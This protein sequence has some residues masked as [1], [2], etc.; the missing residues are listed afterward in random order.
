MSYV[1]KRI[2]VKNFGVLD[3]KDP[4]VVEVP[5]ESR[6]FARKA[7]LHWRAMD[8]LQ[9]MQEAAAKDG[10]SLRISNGLRR[11][12]KLSQEDWE[13]QAIKQYWG[14]GETYAQARAKLYRYR[15]YSGPHET[16][17]VVDFHDGGLEA[18]SATIARQKQ[19]KAFAWLKEHASDYGWHPY[20]A[21]PWHW[22]LGTTT[23]RQWEAMP[24]DIGPLA[25]I[26]IP[27]A[28]KVGAVAAVVVAGIIIGISLASS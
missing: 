23:K 22:E 7:W 20:K 12:K 17:L 3:P 18:K 15:S 26:S 11:K 13:E 14:K 8:A 1:E 21:E 27:G 5:R 10:I 25:D 6:A 24:G 4:R 2:R 9:E 19:T 16:G 28:V